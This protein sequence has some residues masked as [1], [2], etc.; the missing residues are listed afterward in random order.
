[1]KEEF[2]HYIWKYK[3]YKTDNLKS[4][5]GEKIEIIKPGSHNFDAGPDFFNAKIKIDN[6]IWSGNVEVHINSSDWYSHNHHLNK[7]FDNVILQVVLNHDKDIYRTNGHLIQTL[8][9]KF[10]KR[11]LNNYENLLKNK[12]W[13][14]CE[15][16]IV[17]I[18]KFIIDQWIEKLAIERL[19]EKSERIN[20]I[21]ILS[22]NN[23][24]SAFYIQL[25]R[26]FGFKLNSEPFELLAKS[27]PL[28][29]LAK[30]KNNLL[31]IEALLFGQAGFLNDPQGDEYYKSLQK[32]YLFLKAKF[33]L[34]PIEKHLWKFLRSRP[35]NFP[36]IRIAQFAM[37]IYKSSSLFSKII[38]TEEV[39]DIKELLLIETSD[40]WKTHYLFNK[41]SVNKHKSIGNSSVDILIINT[42]IPFLFVFGKKSSDEKI[43]TRA[44]IFLE[45]NKSEKNT[46]LQNWNK[47]GVQSTNSLTSQALIQLKNYYC[48]NKKC[49]Q[50]MIGNQLIR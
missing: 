37:L 35:G 49:L 46:M 41:E 28:N 13:I 25:A 20:D 6:T 10:D 11:L 9:L 19:E 14:P 18:D 40:Y 15:K 8:E 21:L 42:I 36:T 4:T 34:K 17:K 43:T 33:K 44:L 27:L 1:M 48:D 3:L 24:E 47:I 45:K 16:D 29:Y 39:E 2:L 50:C 23:W 7:A 12:L 30:H 26:N 5:R 31:Q 32:E 38:E 22:N